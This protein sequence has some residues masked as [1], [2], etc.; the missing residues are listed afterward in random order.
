[1]KLTTNKQLQRFKKAS[2][3][4]LL[5]LSLFPNEAFIKAED[6]EGINQEEIVE[7]VEQE[8]TTEVFETQEETITVEE[9]TTQEEIVEEAIVE[10]EVQ[11]VETLEET[12][13]PEPT[14]EVVEEELPQEEPSEEVVEEEQPVAEEVSVYQGGELAAEGKDYAIRL[15]YSEEAC[16]PEGSYLVV[17]EITN[18]HEAYDTY[19]ENAV[20]KVFESE[21]TEATTLPYARFFDITIMTPDGN[22]LEPASAVTVDID[23]KDNALETEDVNFAAVHF[24]EETETNE[25]V[26]IELINIT[27][28]E[29]VSFETEQFSVYGV[30]Y[31]YT[32][33][34]YYELEEYHMNGGSEMMLSSLFEKLGIVKNTAD[35]TE[36]TFTDTS[37]V[38]FTKEGNDYRITSLEPFTTSEVLTIKFADGEEIVIGV[39][40]ATV[41]DRTPSTDLK[42]NWHLD[43]D[44]T[45]TIRPI[46]SIDTAGGS[47]FQTDRTSQAG[48]N[49]FWATGPNAST[50]I[51]NEVTKVVFTK[52]ANGIGIDLNNKE[53]AYMFSGFNNLKSVEIQDGALIGSA[54]SFA[55]MFRNCSSLETADLSGLVSEEEALYDM[56]H[57]FDGCSSLT[58]VTMNNEKL[59]TRSSGGGVNMKEM[60]KGCDSLET[61]D[62]SNIT[63]YGRTTNDDWDQ[64]NNLFKDLTSLTTVKLNNTKVPG[65]RK[66]Q[67]MFEGCTNLTTVEME[68]FTPSDAVWMT[69]MFKD[70]TSLEKLD[71]SSFGVLSQIV[72][73][74]HFVQNDTA[75]KELILDNLDNSV[76]G[77]TNERHNL[78]DGRTN[79]KT[80][81]ME[82]GRMLDIHT[83]TAL[84]TLSAKDAKIWMVHNNRGLPGSEYFNASNYKDTYYFTDKAMEFESDAGPTVTIDSDR[85]YI[86]L[87]TD[88]DGTTVNTPDASGVGGIADTGTNINI[89]DGDLNPNGPGF[90]A[91]GVYTLNG[92]RSEPA[93]PEMPDTYYRIAY[94]N[95]SNFTV[96]IQNDPNGELV[97]SDNDGTYYINTVNKEIEYGWPLSGNYDIPC[98]IVITYEN[99]AIDVNG[100]LHDVVITINKITFKDL[101][102]IKFRHNYEAQDGTVYTGV[103]DWD[104]YPGHED[105]DWYNMYID[106]YG[107]YYRTVM[108]VKPND[109]LLFQ[110]YVYLGDPYTPWDRDSNFKAISGGSGTDID[111]KVEIADANPDTTFI[112]KVEDLDVP[113]AQNYQVRDNYTPDGWNPPYYDA[114]LDELTPSNTTYGLDAESVVLGDGNKIDTVTFAD[115]TGLKLVGNQVVPTGSDP[116]TSWS[117]FIVQA[118]ATGSDYTWKSGIACETYALRDTPEIIMGEI[119][120][121]LRAK[122]VL[123]GDT[124]EAG[125]F[126]FEMRKKEYT[127]IDLPEPEMSKGLPIVESNEADGTIYFGTFTFADDEN[128]QYIDHSAN[129]GYFPG[130]DPT[131]NSNGNGEHNTLLTDRDNR[132][133]YEYTVKEIPGTDPNTTYDTSE[134]TLKIQFYTPENDGEMLKGIKAEIYVDGVLVKEVWSRTSTEAEIVNIAEFLN[135]KEKEFVVTKTWDDFSDLYGLRPSDLPIE[136]TYTYNDET[137]TIQTVPE[138]WAKNGDTWKYTFKLP[139][140][141]TN[142][143]FTEEVPTHYE[144]SQ[145]E[146]VNEE[147]TEGT[148]ENKLILYNLDVSKLV[149]G[150]MGD[151][152]DTFEFTIK[153]DKLTTINDT[154]SEVVEKRFRSTNDHSDVLV[155]IFGKQSL[156]TAD[157]DRIMAEKQLQMK[158]G[159]GVFTNLPKAAF[160]YMGDD[161]GALSSQSTQYA[162]DGRDYVTGDNVDYTQMYQDGDPI[163]LRYY[164]C[165]DLSAYGGQDNNDGT[166]TFTLGHGESFRIP[167]IPYGYT[168]TIEET[169]ES[170]EDKGYTTKVDGVDGRIA[171]GTIVGNTE[172]EYK[173]IREG[174]IPT[175]AFGG[176]ATPFIALSLLGVVWFL[177]RLRTRYFQED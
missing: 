95:S 9:E 73:M 111:F 142:I 106:D 149:E 49:A 2:I 50:Y 61:V 147:E 92:S 163:A 58:T 32:V 91:P 83:C 84:E 30:V 152:E 72:N 156:S 60:F 159:N 18:A 85:D 13:N 12:P 93:E 66:F 44:G 122:K 143:S 138:E 102:K 109:G 34:F 75:F 81:A 141:A 74:D 28:D 15:A 51:R 129:F 24:V 59:T 148:V 150:S 77:P 65:M 116:W 119:T 27:T 124:L 37:L 52:N 88:R 67:S 29:T 104:A 158:V 170:S 153:I 103:D 157:V 151:K 68:G 76:I 42:I 107:E 63:L 115:E 87:V 166:Y 133:T 1:M 94:L 123:E 168:Y 89:K 23:L 41:R 25:V 45:L 35:I 137:E 78:G 17:E 118:D 127:P 145:E 4:F 6:E 175:K 130:T 113:E 8:E 114:C 98:K 112:F 177:Y 55:S 100:K 10:E 128:N 96:D 31:Y 5:A 22:P 7:T 48:W 117:E 38:T 164:D 173:N 144:K 39:E 140:K 131:N 154:L 21:D 169:K 79:E 3:A 126:K 172:V 101:D 36:L 53:L 162:Y 71:V 176:I 80:G 99:A 26:D 97:L 56:Q 82:Y 135:K 16:I 120:L 108:Q 20:N 14:P 136:L 125:D 62:M 46:N 134:R 121:D 11:E 132:F 40:D 160:Y 57:M 19:V 90:L 54:Q 174:V 165:L 70:C 139:F 86:D 69:N 64:C 161:R 167:N 47:A 43:A 171:T 146:T 110:N 33:D 155:K 105:H